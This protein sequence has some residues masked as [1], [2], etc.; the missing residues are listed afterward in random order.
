MADPTSGPYL[1]TGPQP[2]KAKPASTFSSTEIVEKLSTAVAE[3]DAALNQATFEGAE[4][5][6][7]NYY[8]ISILDELVP[9]TAQT[10]YTG[11]TS[12]RQNESGRNP[13]YLKSYFNGWDEFLQL[14]PEQ[15]SV[16]QPYFKLSLVQRDKN[17]ARWSEITR[18]R[19]CFEGPSPV[20]LDPTATLSEQYNEPV[21]GLKTNWRRN[22]DW[23]PWQEST[24]NS[25]TCFW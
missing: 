19:S 20:L 13:S 15:A 12:L 16:L 7:D 11:W 25:S 24:N 23:Y 6:T 3:K 17:G 22:W 8:L 10:K 14:R 5:F 18:G 4:N 2:A 21:I 9:L 1:P